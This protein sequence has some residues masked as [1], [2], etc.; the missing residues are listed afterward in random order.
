MFLT[1]KF[2]RRDRRVKERAESRER[3]RE[4]A[5]KRIRKREREQGNIGKDGNGNRKI[6]SM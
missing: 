1:V 5:R 2:E 3:E 6:K 4:W